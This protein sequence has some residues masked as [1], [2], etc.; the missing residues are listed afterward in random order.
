MHLLNIISPSFASV[1][2]LTF[3]VLALVKYIPLLYL[4]QLPF[5]FFTFL[6]CSLSPNLCPGSSCCIYPLNPI[7]SV[8]ASLRPSYTC[9]GQI[10][11]PRQTKVSIYTAPMTPGFICTY[12]YSFMCHNLL[13]LVY[14]SFFLI[15][16][17][18]F[19]ISVPNS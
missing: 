19:L 10:I 2:S 12:L 17:N 3:Q 4:Y 7:K 9:K 5:F 15:T 18:S 11:T 1:F 14:R 8:T 16:F 13:Q 6:C